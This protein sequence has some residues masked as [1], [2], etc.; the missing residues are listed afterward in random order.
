MAS[1]EKFVKTKCQKCRGSA[2]RETDVSDTFLD[3]SWY[4]LRY[5]ST[6]FKKVP[7]DKTLTKKWLPVDMYIGGQEHAVLHLL[8][9]RFITMALKDLKIVS[10]EEPFEKFRA[11]GLLTKGG[12]KMSK[13]KG[14]VVNPDDYYQ[15]FGADTLRV[16]LMFL[17]PFQEG[18]DWQDLGIIGVKRF[19]EKV[20]KLKSQITNNKSQTNPKLEKLI[21][22]TIKKVTEDIENLRYNTAIS[23]LMILANAMEKSSEIQNTSYKILLLLLAPFAPYITEELWYKLGDKES[24]HNQKWPEYDEKLIKEEKINL[25]IQING[26]VRDK[27]EVKAGI[28]KEEAKQLTLQR[29]KVKQWISGKEIKKIIFVK[30][31]LINIV[32]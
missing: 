2:R 1:V 20:W 10:F 27:I 9:A 19:L 16:Y 28:S 4:F 6:D 30:D 8:Y 7:F 21:N 22:Q 29:E 11:N 3:S 17:G 5:P 25:I 23:I 26:K 31:K 32:I 18:G 15:K 13:S 12:A 24:I 14:N